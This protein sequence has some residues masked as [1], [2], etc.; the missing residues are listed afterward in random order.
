MPGLL[1]STDNGLA[2]L[3]FAAAFFAELIGVM[4]FTLYGSAAGRNSVYAPWG[5]GIALVV[6]G[7]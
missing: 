1:Q 6:L 7:E 4:L 5:N 2:S 3:K